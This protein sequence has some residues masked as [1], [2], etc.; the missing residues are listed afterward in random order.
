MTFAENVDWSK[1]FG[2]GKADSKDRERLHQVT[3][4]GRSEVMRLP[5]ATYLT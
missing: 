2:K 1:I 5:G 3:I 4:V